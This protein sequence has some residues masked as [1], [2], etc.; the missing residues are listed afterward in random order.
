MS[1]KKNDENEWAF[2]PPVTGEQTYI[3]LF[4]TVG[5]K[6]PGLALRLKGVGLAVI[7]KI[8]KFTSFA[9]K[10]TNAINSIP[11]S[12]ALTS[13]LTPVT[14]IINP[15]LLRLV[16]YSKYLHNLVNWAKFGSRELKLF[17]TMNH[18]LNTFLSRNKVGPKSLMLNV[19]GSSEIFQPV[20]S[21]GSQ[22]S[23]SM[24]MRNNT[25]EV[26]IYSV[27]SYVDKKD[28]SV[29]KAKFLIHSNEQYFAVQHNPSKYGCSTNDNNTPC[30]LYTSPSPRDKRQSRM[31]S[32][33]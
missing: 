14:K 8:N 26:K 15:N 33:A 32:S 4:D 17:S 19:E 12:S 3:C 13:E 25:R 30:L 22:L 6:T 18:V 9:D 24:Y 31:P 16:G 11:A 21:S 10:L 20:R 23:G 7:N 2:F 27:Q 29:L 5:L 1:Y 28:L